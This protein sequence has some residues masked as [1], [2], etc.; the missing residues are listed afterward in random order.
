MLTD[1]LHI[2]F[3]ITLTAIP[4]LL[5]VAYDFVRKNKGEA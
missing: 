2:L 3:T 5:K 1:H 4:V